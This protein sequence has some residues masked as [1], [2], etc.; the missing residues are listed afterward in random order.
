VL[1]LSGQSLVPV[2]IDGEDVVADSTR[3]IERLEE[4]FP[5]PPLYPND[6]AR[7][8]EVAIFVDWFNRV[9][10]RFP[11]EIEGQLVDPEPDPTTSV[12]LESAHMRAALD[13]FEALLSGRDY[14]FGEFG[15][16]DCI[17][18]PFLKYA[19]LGLPAEDDELFH[20]ILVEHQPLGDG[21]PRLK[22]WVLRVDTHPRS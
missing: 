5:E 16:A 19:V 12:A 1:E 20:R 21:Y 9:W 14:L 13:R 22:A 2:L 18:F 11:N 3:I 4:R 10:K 15:A 17:A 8:A 6:E 7:R